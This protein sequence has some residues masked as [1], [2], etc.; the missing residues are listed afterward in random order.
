MVGLYTN[1]LEGQHAFVKTTVDTTFPSN[2]RILQKVL[3]SLRD[4]I[5]KVEM[6]IMSQ[7]MKCDKPCTVSCPVPVVSGKECEDIFRKGGD[8]SE[9]YLIQPD[10]FFN[11]YKVYCDMTTEKGGKW[12]KVILAP[13]LPQLICGEC[14]GTKWLPC[15]PQVRRHM[16]ALCFIGWT[17]IQN[18][19]DG[20]VNF[21]RRWDDYR[22]GFGNIA[23]DSG[24][25]FCNTPGESA[26]K[27]INRHIATPVLILRIQ[28]KVHRGG[29][30]RRQKISHVFLLPII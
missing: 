6:A 2:I 9:M 29:K 17:L 12:L 15:I 20:S 28:P 3:E 8:S 26:G 30:S 4:K 13:R 7:K 11:P 22:S 16:R 19:Q 5:Q 1:D 27:P 14:S 24:K 18:R 23:S 21:G 10:S 25:G